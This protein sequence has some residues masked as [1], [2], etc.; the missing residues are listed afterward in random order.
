M[1]PYLYILALFFFLPNSCFSQTMVYSLAVDT[2]GDGSVYTS[3]DCGGMWKADEEVTSW[4]AC[5]GGLTTPLPLAFHTI[6]CAAIAPSNNSIMYCGSTNGHVYRSNNGGDTWIDTGLNLRKVVRALAIDPFDA[7]HVYAAGEP[8]LFEQKKGT[9][10][11]KVLPGGNRIFE[12]IAFD[13]FDSKIIHAITQNIAGNGSILTS[14]DSGVTWRDSTLNYG[15]IRIGFDLN[16]EGTLYLGTHGGVY[17]SVNDGVTWD[18]LS[19]GFPHKLVTAIIVDPV[20]SQLVY[21]GTMDGLY[22]SEN[23]GSSWSNTNLV[24]GMITNLAFSR[25]EDSL[26]IGTARYGIIKH[27]L[28]E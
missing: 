1:K 6:L 17:K 27:A 15:V 26:F 24:E 19:S 9:T 4:T 12:D 20:E 23:G 14:R 18:F 25:D 5:S 13:P 11:Q 7:N 2:T 22:M 10:W 16:N 3:T 28:T 21:A 8:G